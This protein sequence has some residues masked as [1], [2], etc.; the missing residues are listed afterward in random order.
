M[1]TGSFYHNKRM[2]RGNS[3]YS[4]KVQRGAEAARNVPIPCFLSGSLPQFTAINW[5]FQ[6]QNGEF[7]AFFP[8]LRRL[9]GKVKRK[10]QRGN[11]QSGEH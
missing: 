1:A 9:H 8:P 2:P 6:K 7:L 5:V 11:R 3:F 10:T 4:A